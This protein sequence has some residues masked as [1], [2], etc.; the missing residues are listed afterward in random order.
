MVHS[1]SV[2]VPNY[3]VYISERTWCF[4]NSSWISDCLTLRADG[5]ICRCKPGAQQGPRRSSKDKLESA[6]GHTNKTGRQVQDG[7]ILIAK[8]CS[9]L[10]SHRS[11]GKLHLS[12]GQD[13]IPFP[14]CPFFCSFLCSSLQSA[15]HLPSSPL[16]FISLQALQSLGRNLRVYYINKKMFRIECLK[17]DGANQRKTQ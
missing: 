17:L 4:H 8:L 1:L 16:I 3:F 12:S 13:V 15:F 6:M 14:P 10:L 2:V 7:S 11:S 9:Q 5:G